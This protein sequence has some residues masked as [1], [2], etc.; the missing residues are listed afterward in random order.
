MT[1]PGGFFL[2]SFLRRLVDN[3]CDIAVLE[4]TS[5]GIKQQRHRCIDFSVAVC[6]NLQPEHL[7]SHGAF[8]HY[9]NAKSQI[10]RRAKMI[11]INGDDAEAREFLSFPAERTVTYGFRRTDVDVQ[12]AVSNVGFDHQTLHVVS[13]NKDFTV[14]L[15][16]GGPFAAANALA[17]VAVATC[18]EVDAQTIASVLEHLPTVPGRFEI[19]SRTPFVIVDYAHTIAAVEKLLSFLRSSWKGKIVHVFGAAGGG[20][21]RWKRPRLAEL[22]ETNTDV[23]ILTE[24]NPFDEEPNH[25]VKDIFQGFRDPTRVKIFPRREDA[26]RAALDLADE[27]T[28]CIFAS[29]GCETVIAGPLGRKRPYNERQAILSALGRH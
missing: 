20:R 16:L 17:A 23:S 12:G 7:E 2:Q 18:F 8:R 15:P 5:E 13:N 9:K 10:F 6:T 26:V 4:V 27:K 11:V 1:M 25:I 19:V 29:K 22:S 14:T 24:E 28:L 21:D 3:G